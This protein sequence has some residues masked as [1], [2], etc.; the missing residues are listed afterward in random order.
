M[1][2]C[3]RA[4]RS[5][6]GWPANSAWPKLACSVDGKHSRRL[7]GRSSRRFLGT[8]RPQ[9]QRRK[10]LIR[11]LADTVAEEATKHPDKPIE[12]W[13]EDEHRLGLKPIHRRVWAPIG[14]RPIAL[15]HHRYEW[16][17]LTAFVAPASG[18]TVWYLSNGINKPFFAELLSAFA[19][20]TGAGRERII[21]LALDNAGWH[22]PQNLPV[23]DGVRLIYQPSYSPE[24][25]P[26]EHLWPL[27]DEPLV[28]RYFDTIGDLDAVVAQ[29]CCVLHQDQNKIAKS[30]NFH[31]WPKQIGRASCRER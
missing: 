9:A 11:K 5:H 15:G 14:E 10:R 17:Y 2:V 1:A 31:W 27:V 12:V 16:L 4:A 13:A 28:N 20:E 24:L 18:E 25:Q 23:P 6:I 3:G 21:I 19:R 26:A 7:A 30:T 22:G 29:R 8:C